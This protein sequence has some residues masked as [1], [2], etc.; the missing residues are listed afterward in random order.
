MYIY[1]IVISANCYV[2]RLPIVAVFR[3]VFFEGILHRMFKQFT[4]TQYSFLGQGLKIYV[5]I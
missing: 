2:F 4:D 3:E 5:R 1:Y